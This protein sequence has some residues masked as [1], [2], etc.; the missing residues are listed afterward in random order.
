MGIL[1]EWLTEGVLS[2]ELG[3][4]HRAEQGRATPAVAQDCGVTYSRGSVRWATASSS[5]G[6]PKSGRDTPPA[7]SPGCA[8]GL[9]AWASL[10]R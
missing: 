6:G 2:A 3:R 7:Q 10:T 9:C 5:A 8:L 1:G 4:Q